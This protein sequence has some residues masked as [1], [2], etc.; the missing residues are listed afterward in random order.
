VTLRPLPRSRLEGLIPSLVQGHALVALVAGTGDDRWAADA[1]WAVA[2]AAQAGGRRVALVDLWMTEP[3]L[4]HR[5]GIAPDAPGIVDVFERNAELSAAAQDVGGVYF[6]PAGSRSEAPEFVLAHPRWKK[7][8]AGFK[9]EGALLLTYLSAGSLA[10]LSAI[11]DAVIVLAPGGFDMASPLARDVQAAQVDGAMLLGV[12]R[13][14]WTPPPMAM[15]A[16]ESMP[17]VSP[18]LAPRRTGGR[19]I[20]V[21][22]GVLAILGAAAGAWVLLRGRGAASTVEA[23]EQPAT[24]EPAATPAAPVGPDP[25]EAAAPATS[26]DTLDWA[27]QLAAYA[28]VVNALAHVDEL[29]AAGEPAL[30]AP[31]TPSGSRVVWYRVFTG[32]W[33]ARAAAAAGRD[34]L[35]IRGLARRGE[36]EVVRAPLVLALGGSEDAATLRRRGIPATPV[37]RRLVIGPFE[38]AEQAAPMMQQL[39][40][41]GVPAELVPR[42]ERTP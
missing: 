24:Q 20:P 2:R 27:I 17:A 4:S 31:V 16:E 42:L 14:R 3:Q 22:V 34:S 37:G 39:S 18:R 8:H 5:A 41:A 35:W 36:G 11:P 40:R 15:P 28:N 21:A 38:S 29:A 13:E 6:I 30:V 19:R 9:A 1:A 32:G 25:D 23:P 26:S 33:P 10:S 12:V 7:L